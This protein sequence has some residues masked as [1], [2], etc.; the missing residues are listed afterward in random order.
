VE[1]KISNE[2]GQRYFPL[3]T[4]RLKRCYFL[5][6]KMYQFENPKGGRSSRI[7]LEKQL[8]KELNR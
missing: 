2:G 1:T 3:E 5:R 4:L 8:E 7:L 6:F